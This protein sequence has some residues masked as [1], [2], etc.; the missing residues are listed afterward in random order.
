MSSVRKVASSFLSLAVVVG[1]ILAVVNRQQIID[2]ITLWQYQP[3]EQIA[4]IAS[5]AK[6]SETGKKMFY[7]SKPQLKSAN[8]F[9][10]DCRR[11]EK[12][13]AILG[14]YNQS[15]GEIYVYD[16]TN[17]ELDGVKEVT[18][19]HEMLHAAYARL[20]TE[21]KSRLEPLLEQAY[22]K[23]KTD[24]FTERMNYYERAQPGSRTNEL[25]S[26]LGTEFADLG[27]ELEQYYTRYFSDRSAVV[28]LHA[29]YSNKFDSVENEAN[30]LRTNLAARK[31]DIESRANQYAADVEQ[32]NQRVKAFNQKAA[33]GGFAS[34][35]DFNAQRSVLRSRLTEINR[36][37]TALNNDIS[38]YNKDVARLR[39]LGVKIDELNKSLDSVEGGR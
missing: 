37:R 20:S 25:H 36:R 38:Q 23:V 3:S 10:E 12:G 19:A 21:E 27:S 35:E 32:Y 11:V 7:I 18:A 39:E 31:L 30:S 24:K 1:A 34:Q 9:N 15:S 26:I 5:R 16:V 2:E 29:Q 28:K 4:T 17:P 33:D 14:C 6:M 22:Q 8:E 13:N